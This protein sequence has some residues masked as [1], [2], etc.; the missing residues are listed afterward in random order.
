MRSWKKEK[1]MT[2]VFFSVTGMLLSEAHHKHDDAVGEWGLGRPNHRG[3]ML[4]QFCKRRK[5]VVTNTLFEQHPRRRYTWKAAGDTARYQIDYILVNQR[6]KN[7]V[8]RSLAYPG[9]DCDSDHNLVMVTVQLKLKKMRGSSK[10][11]RIDNAKLKQNALVYLS[12]VQSRLYAREF[13]KGPSV[14]DEWENLKGA[15]HGND[16]ENVGFGK[17]KKIRKPW[18]T[19]EMIDKMDQRRTLKKNNTAEG[20]RGYKRLNNELKRATKP[21]LTGGNNARNKRS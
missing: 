9:A 16:K 19:E 15:L 18:I 5:L 21:E 12:G 10:V 17:R 3:N 13:P 4:V 11:T 1:E 7:S 20:K 2:T 14:E 6:Y 8:K